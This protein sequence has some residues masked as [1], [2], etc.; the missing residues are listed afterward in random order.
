MEAGVGQNPAQ[1]SLFR[2][3]LAPVEWVVEGLGAF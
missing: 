3:S 2:S 1:S